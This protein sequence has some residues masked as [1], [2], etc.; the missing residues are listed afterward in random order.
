[1]VGA[2]GSSSMAG[3]MDDTFSFSFPSFHRWEF[4]TRKIGDPRL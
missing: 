2:V 1:M 4:E 3:M